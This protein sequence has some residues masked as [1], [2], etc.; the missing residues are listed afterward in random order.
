MPP[1]F[2]LGL[3]VGLCCFPLGFKLGVYSQY[4]KDVKKFND[5]KWVR[6]SGDCGVVG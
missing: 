1:I 4:G 5:N 6:L 3:A 2:Y